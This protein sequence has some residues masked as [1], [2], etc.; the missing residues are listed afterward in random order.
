MSSKEFKALWMQYE[1]FI[2][3]VVDV[4]HP[5]VEAA[6]HD[7]QKGKIVAIYHNI[8]QRKVGEPSPLKELKIKTEN[9]PDY[10]SPYYKEN[11]DGRSLKCTSITIRNKKGKPI[12]LICINVDASYFQ[13]GFR[14]LQAFL[15]TRDEAENPVEIFGTQCEEHAEEVIKLFLNERNLSLNHLNRDHKRDLVQELYRKGIFNFKNA[16]PFIA[17]KLKTSRASVYNYIKCI[18]EN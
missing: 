4:F 9:F 3:A 15:K 11:W 2:K 12:G 7:L 8:S 17:K 18:S 14:L 6:V 13:D 5:F 10:F 1:P 16:A